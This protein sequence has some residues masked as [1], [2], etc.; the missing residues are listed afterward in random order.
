MSWFT[1]DQAVIEHGSDYL[2]VASLTL[3]AYPV[4]F[5]TVFLLQ[6]LKRPAYGLWIGLY[7]QI[8][9]PRMVFHL[10]AFT[11]GWGLWGIW[12][13][14]SLVTWS[15]ALFTLWWGART[16]RQVNAPTSVL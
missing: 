8:I 1:K 15:A 13:G 3:C 5:Q 16:L 12:W 10:L 4:L 11:L 9:A 7:R 2:L 14:I 6:G